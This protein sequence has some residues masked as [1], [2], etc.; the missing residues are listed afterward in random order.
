MEK[1]ELE[2]LTY[3]ELKKIAKEKGVPAQ[4]K[5]DVLISKILEIDLNPDLVDQETETE[6]NPD[7]EDQEEEDLGDLE[8]EKEINFLELVD[9]AIFSKISYKTINSKKKL[10]EEFEKQQGLD[11][12]QKIINWTLKELMSNKYL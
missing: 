7:L 11:T 3:Q 6:T 8:E 9:K 5:K 4:Q 12:E 2:E 10:I 1:Q